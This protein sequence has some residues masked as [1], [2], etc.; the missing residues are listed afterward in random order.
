MPSLNGYGEYAGSW[1]A[2]SVSVTTDTA[3]QAFVTDGLA[4][5]LNITNICANDKLKD[6]GIPDKITVMGTNSKINFPTNLTELNPMFTSTFTVGSSSYRQPQKN[7]NTNAAAF[8]TTNGESIAVFY[9]PYCQ[10]DMGETTWHYTQPKMCADLVYDLNGRKGPNTVGKDIGFIIA[11]Y[12]TDSEVV[13]PMP[14]E[15][16]AK[17]GN[18]TTMS[19]TVAVVACRTQNKDSR[20]PNREELTAMFYNKELIGIS[21]GTSLLTF[22]SGALYSSDSSKAWLQGFDVGNRYRDSRTLRAYVRCIKR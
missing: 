13:A 12:P 7:I 18:L 16:N 4:K 1:S 15:K 9:N 10:S 8:E 5:V 20:L 14:L 6:C 21:S 11:L 22:W 2:D 19:Q 3:A 17:Y